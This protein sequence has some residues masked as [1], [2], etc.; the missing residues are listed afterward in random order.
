MDRPHY[1]RRYKDKDDIAINLPTG[2]TCGDCYHFNQCNSM[3]GHIALDER[4]DWLP[5]RF[6]EPYEA[7]K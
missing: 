5:S 7:T 2:K 3:F 6:I 4:C 1:E